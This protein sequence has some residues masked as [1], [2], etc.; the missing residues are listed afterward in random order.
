[1]FGVGAAAGLAAAAATARVLSMLLYDVSAFDPL[2]FVA[3][4]L[5]L[6]TAG[7]GACYLPARRAVRVDPS[8]ALRAE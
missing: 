6:C 4:T 2:S 8:I 5:V 7:L 3:S 1:L